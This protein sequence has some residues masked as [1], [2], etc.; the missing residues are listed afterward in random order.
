MRQT[1]R[2]LL[3]LLAKVLPVNG[4]RVACQRAK[5]VRIG[6]NVYLAPYTHVSGVPDQVVRRFDIG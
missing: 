3:D 4:W 1:W 2:R 5:G 6:R